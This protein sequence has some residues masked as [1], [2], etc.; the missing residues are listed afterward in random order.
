MTLEALTVVVRA[1]LYIDLLA[2]FG[3]IAFGLYGMQSA[4][5]AVGALCLRTGVVGLAA[6]GLV[7]SL[8]QIV[9]M[10]SAMAGTPLFPVNAEAVQILV[11]KT[12]IGSAWK[13]RMFALFALLPTVLLVRSKALVALALMGI[14]A[15]IAVATLAWAGHGAMDSGAIGWV[16]LGADVLHLLAAAG[17]VGAVLALC[18]L[19]FHP[20]A[21]VDREQIAHLDNALQG[22]AFTGTVLVA[23]IL[24]T[25]LVNVW[26][27]VGRPH[28]LALPESDYGRLLIAKVMFFLLMLCLAAANRFR[29]SP[30]LGRA[31]L[32]GGVVAALGA[33]RI[34]LLLEI[35][36]ALIILSI[37]AWLGTLAPT[38]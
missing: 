24:V 7:I 28:L 5:H 6:A 16:H 20:H 21:A 4:E 29:L 23:V 22:F 12:L 17:W 30:A 38:K 26:I 3:M 14:W 18:M 25:G 34:S 9:A 1:L 36:C 31:R 33:L 35:G 37:A 2:L 32:D 27:I 19:L 8:V 13:V 10:A 15:A 11:G